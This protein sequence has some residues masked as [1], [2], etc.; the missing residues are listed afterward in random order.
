MNY[1]GTVLSLLYCSA[2][3]ALLAGIVLPIYTVSWCMS[4]TLWGW[5]CLKTRRLVQLINAQIKSLFRFILEYL[6]TACL[7]VWSVLLF[8][9][10]LWYSEIYWI[11]ISLLW[12]FRVN[13]I[14]WDLNARHC[15][16]F[17]SWRLRCAIAAWK[18]SIT[19]IDFWLL[20]QRAI[21]RALQ[22]SVSLALNTFFSILSEISWK[23]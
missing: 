23:C 12:F 15:L 14:W 5:S 20:S 16:C 18:S 13:I 4:I 7:A 1:T 9:L 3:S 11:I 21:S 6:E 17:I 8:S 19:V 22:I 2:C 10:M